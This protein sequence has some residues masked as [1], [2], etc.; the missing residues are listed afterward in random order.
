ML[1][2]NSYTLRMVLKIRLIVYVC[3][4]KNEDTGGGTT[5]IEING[6]PVEP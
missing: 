1:D 6:V 5:S 2:E 3:Q 4:C